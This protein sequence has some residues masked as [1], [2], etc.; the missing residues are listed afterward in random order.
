MKQ[1]VATQAPPL[2]KIAALTSLRFFAALFVVLYHVTGIYLPWTQQ[3]SILVNFVALGYISVSFFFLLSGYILAVVYLRRGGPVA[4]A[5]FY[6]ARF[7]RV[8]PLF[9]ITLILDTP[10]LFL[11]RWTTYGLKSAVLKTAI[12]FAGNTV[13][14]Q[15]W[16]LRLRGIDNPNWSLS[17]ETLFYLI[18][19][20]LGVVLWKLRG[21]KLGLTAALVYLGGQALVFALTLH[22]PREL[23]ELCP[24]VHVTTFVLGILLARWQWLKKQE[25]G[26]GARGTSPGILLLVTTLALAGFG[27]VL[28]WAPGENA[29]VRDGLLAPIFAAFIWAFSHSNWFFAKV[30]SARWLVVL[31][32]AS[33]G[34]YLIHFPVTHFFERQGWVHSPFMFPVFLTSCIG[35]SVLS[36]YYFETPIRSKLLKQR[37]MHVK[38]TMEMA[39]D[40]Q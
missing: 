14:L 3:S 40:A 17:V 25:K 7:A 27:A 33:F 5:P 28:Y 9:F 1:Q 8:Y 24:C 37:K 4:V 22:F 31:G 26:D 19:P 16:F 29:N 21:F 18:F 36:F 2:E 32:E 12:T 20:F 34:L 39:S 23:F 11:S 30:L 13:M 35:L 15:A 6:R 10:F 38:E